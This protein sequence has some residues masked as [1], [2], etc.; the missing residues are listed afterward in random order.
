MADAQDEDIKGKTPPPPEPGAEGESP[1]LQR[2]SSSRKT[3]D[4]GE[5]KKEKKESSSSKPKRTDSSS[6][7]KPAAK[8]T[9]AAAA[10]AAEGEQKDLMKMIVQQNRKQ[11]LQNAEWSAIFV[12]SQGCGKSTLLQKFL[13]AE[14]QGDPK[15]TLALEYSFARRTSKTAP[16]VKEVA[17]L[18]EVGG[19][20]AL[21]NLLDV[22][23]NEASLKTAAVVIC[24]DLSKPSEVFSMV[25]FWLEQL[26]ARIHKLESA[27]QKVPA[28]AKLMEQL[29]QRAAKRFAI[30]S[31]TPG[32]DK[33][34]EK[35]EDD[36]V[37]KH[38]GVTVLIAACKF[39][40]FSSAAEAKLKRTVGRCLRF[41][42]HANGASLLYVSKEDK[43]SVN[44][45][46]TLLSHYLFK[47]PAIPA[48]SKQ[49]DHLQHMLIMAGSDSLKDIGMPLRPEEMSQM[50]SA[51][52][53]WRKKWE[54]DCGKAPTIK[55]GPE[56]VPEL[57]PKGQY[58]ERQVDTALVQK[59]QDLKL[60]LSS[61]QQ[62]EK[63]SDA[64]KPLARAG[65]S[66]T[67]AS[68]SSKRA[69]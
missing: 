20:T 67:A 49:P 68:S 61:Q 28:K 39:D 50:S 44:N 42:A 54:E 1:P 4:G 30:A 52:D 34:P 51:T 2:K 21:A 60:Y 59:E 65:S 14:G 43:Q 12:G 62:E 23:V 32:A 56:A 24:A 15:P 69:N 17:H 35:H 11:A 18:W 25:S 22:P 47:G 58:K 19:G 36:G 38:M 6:A 66:K 10:D 37:V 3:V 45:F 64:K 7:L 48:K 29:R 40:A 8:A 33:A 26:R 27:M 31:A 41:L 46:R 53:A 55:A 16:G 13:M 9:G 57:D 63:K 5:E